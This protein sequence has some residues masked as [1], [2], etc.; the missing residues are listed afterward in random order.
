MRLFVT[1]RVN[2]T[3]SSFVTVISLPLVLLVRTD[4]VGD[5]H[6]LSGA[7]GPCADG[8][9]NIGRCSGRRRCLAQFA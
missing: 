1:V 3:F 4:C 7:R 8:M 5:C 9:Y 2:L 6:T